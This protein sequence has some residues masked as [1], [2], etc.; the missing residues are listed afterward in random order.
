MDRRTR[1]LLVVGLAAVL[2]TAGLVYMNSA[3]AQSSPNAITLPERW[4]Y[5]AEFM[6]GFQPDKG[7]PPIEP[8]VK[9]GNYATVV[10][11]F[12]PTASAV[13]I[14]KRIVLMTPEQYPTTAFNKPTKRFNEKLPSNRALG[15]D[16]KEVVNLLTQ[17]GT[18]PAAG[19]TMI[20]GYLIV[21][22]SIGGKVAA[23]LD[24]VATYTTATAPDTPVNS[25]EVVP[26]NG[27]LLP[28]GTWPF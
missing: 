5:S 1:I 13:D 17:N 4:S 9:M 14:S 7:A 19:V 20:A 8:G 6:C 22:S 12:N 15:V 21:E 10:N 3:S 11:F 27:R 23:Q 18:P 16:C 24:V 2:F 28:A 25:L 26:I